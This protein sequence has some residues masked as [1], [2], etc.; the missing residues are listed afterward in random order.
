VLFS[1][2]SGVI[3]S[4]GRLKD[5]LNSSRYYIY[6]FMSVWKI[7]LFMVCIM[8]SIWMEGDEPS[9]FFQMFNAG[10]SPH[11]IVVEEVSI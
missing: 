5:E 2:L 11:N 10:F 6:R 9:M 1:I 8:M 4:L 3:K 7:L